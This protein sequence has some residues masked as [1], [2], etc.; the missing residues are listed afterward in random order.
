MSSLLKS[1]LVLNSQW[2]GN[3]YM[4]YRAR[5]IITQNE[6]ENTVQ[7]ERSSSLL[8]KMNIVQKVEKYTYSIT[9]FLTFLNG[10]KRKLFTQSIIVIQRFWL[11]PRI[12][13]LFIWK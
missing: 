4:Q 11:R 1:L 12:P 9:R 3:A 5:S 8:T 7:I 10:E 13:P 6:R 2:S